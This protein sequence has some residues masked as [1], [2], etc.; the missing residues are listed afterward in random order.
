[1][2]V[3]GLLI[4][5]PLRQSLML[6][7][8]CKEGIQNNFGEFVKIKRICPNPTVDYVQILQ[9]TTGGHCV[10]VGSFKGR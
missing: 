5:L 7:I 8:F 6:N 1:M 4:Q 9:L 10:R 3:D 2:K